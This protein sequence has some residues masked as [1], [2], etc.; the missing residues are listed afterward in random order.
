MKTKYK[1]SVTTLAILVVCIV[2]YIVIPFLKFERIHVYRELVTPDDKT[3]IFLDHIRAYNHYIYVYKGM[4]FNEIPFHGDD[5]KNH[6]ISIKFNWD[7]SIS[8]FENEKEIMA[9][10]RNLI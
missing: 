4:S 3:G 8:I 2:I 5:N 9:E 1:I 6:T 7:Y 10:I